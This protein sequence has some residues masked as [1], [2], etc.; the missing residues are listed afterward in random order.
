M[1]QTIQPASSFEMQSAQTLESSC[2]SINSCESRVS[3]GVRKYS[4]VDGNIL[5]TGQLF[6]LADTNTQNAIVDLGLDA[7]A[8]CVFWES[9]LPGEL[10]K[11]SLEPLLLILLRLAAAVT[12]A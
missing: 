5:N 2:P 7:V 1:L 10:A 3:P 4:E 11:A 9:Q 8:V 6:Q 12:P